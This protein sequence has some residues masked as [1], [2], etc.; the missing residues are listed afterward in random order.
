MA[1]NTCFA[2]YNKSLDLCRVLSTS[3]LQAARCSGNLLHVG[4]IQKESAAFLRFK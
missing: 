2:N 1:A 4:S 3:A